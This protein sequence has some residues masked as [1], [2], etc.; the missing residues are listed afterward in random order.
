M[1]HL[2]LFNEEANKTYSFIKYDT[3]S[4]LSHIMDSGYRVSFSN[5]IRFISVYISKLDGELIDWVDIKDDVLPY[6]EMMDKNYYLVSIETRDTRVGP[7]YTNY[8]THTFNLDLN[9]LTNEKSLKFSL[10]HL[11]FKDN[12]KKIK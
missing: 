3:N 11:Q 1:K 6:L 10:M 8:R 12:R 7:L 2:Y 5:G 4:Y 9:D